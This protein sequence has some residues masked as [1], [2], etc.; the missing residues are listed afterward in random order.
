MARG[1]GEIVCRLGTKSVAAVAV[2]YG[3]SVR[4]V[5]KWKYR[6]AV[7]GPRRFPTHIHTQNDANAV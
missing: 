2:D 1:R 7:G 4:T 6:Y 3:L 5:R